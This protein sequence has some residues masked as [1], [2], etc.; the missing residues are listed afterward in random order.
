M[1]SF[2]M[3][4]LGEAHVLRWIDCRCKRSYI[5]FIVCALITIFSWLVG[6]SK[7]LSK[8]IFKEGK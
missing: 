5:V 1:L 7:E 6:I 4:E 2:E 8:R 3:L